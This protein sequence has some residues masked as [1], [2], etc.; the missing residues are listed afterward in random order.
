M[1]AEF[2]AEGYLEDDMIPLN[3]NRRLFICTNKDILIAKTNI[4]TATNKNYTI[5]LDDTQRMQET[6]YF[7]EIYLVGATFDEIHQ[8]TL[9]EL[10]LLCYEVWT[11]S[12]EDF[13]IENI[14]KNF[15]N[16]N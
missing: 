1:A 8:D 3:L 4:S 13:N 10:K 11:I 16:K 14:L 12:D 15:T 2:F 9:E 5:L 7:N 6:S